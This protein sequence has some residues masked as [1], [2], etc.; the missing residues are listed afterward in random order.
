MQQPETISG[1]CVKHVM[2]RKQLNESEIAKTEQKQQDK[3]LIENPDTFRLL[4]ERSADAMLLLD[5]YVFIDCNQAAVNM[6]GCSDKKQLLSLHPYDI[7][8]EKQPDDRLSCEKEEELITMAVNQGSVRFEWMHQRV[9]GEIFPAE[10]LLT[11]VP[12]KGKKIIHV[13]IRNIT[14]RKQAEELAKVQQ[15]Q[16]IQ[17][18]KM[19]TLGILVSGVAHEINNP[20]NFIML[21]AKIISKTWNDITPILKQ[22]YE[23]NG[24]FILAGM[25]YTK[26]HEKISQLIS[27]ISEG[28]ERIQKIIQ[29]LKDFVRKDREELDQAIDING[30]IQS[31]ILIVNNLIKKSTDH[32]TVEYGKNLPKIRGNFQ[33]LEQVIINLITNSCQA[34]KHKGKSLVVS[35]SHDRSTGNISIKVCDEGTGINPENLKHI[36]DPFF[37]TKRDSGGTGLGLSVSYGIIKDHGGDLNFTSELD[38]GT[39]AII[40][41]P[42][43][44]LPY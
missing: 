11:S 26:A 22:Y 7:S 43:S 18:D 31:A 24:D 5:G 27:G 16:L 41:L 42:I 37:T 9:N 2:P 1:R 30:V 34:L 15:Q 4:F 3:G 14:E 29:S 38:K 28:A 19:A 39:T 32:F 12:V 40:R 25:A 35:T 23:A 20:N 8:P 13:T 36:L 10:V 6:F 17:A 21:N 44:Q 33:Q